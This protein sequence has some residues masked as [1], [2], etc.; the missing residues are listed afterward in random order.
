MTSSSIQVSQTH[1]YRLLRNVALFADVS[2]DLFETIASHCAWQ[3]Y[4]AGQEIVGYGDDSSDVFFVL[5]GMCRV[6]IY[7]TTGRVVGFRELWPGDTF[8]EFAALDQLPR[9][10][11]IE[12]EHDSRLAMM[13]S[14][15]FREIVYNER[16]V[17][18]T[19][20]L[21][22]ISQVRALTVRV[23]EYSTL[24]VN[25]RIEAELLRLV[26]NEIGEGCAP[27]NTFVISPAPTH[28]EL[29]ARISTHREAVTRHLSELSRIGLIKRR[30]R[31]LVITDVK[32][33]Q[34]RVDEAGG[35]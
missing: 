16:T 26:R 13:T 1:D 10:A 18:Q 9:S 20:I 29:A 35:S 25:D 33:L 7:S 2:S 22:L 19:L 6:K 30:G 12:A 31:D 4:K 15:N 5:S 28:A 17:A 34:A 14:E 8:G 24:P 23:L 27:G 3:S 11:S 21:H 32:R